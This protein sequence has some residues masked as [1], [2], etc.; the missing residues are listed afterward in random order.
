ML[1]NSDR[2][3]VDDREIVSSVPVPLNA[4]L[5]IMVGLALSAVLW[6]I[7]IP[8]VWWLVG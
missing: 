3:K 7:I 2:L 5:G 6:A 8:V 4:A 1:F